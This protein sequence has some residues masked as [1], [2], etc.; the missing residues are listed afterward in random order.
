[1]YGPREPSRLNS[2]IDRG[3]RNAL[4]DGATWGR[5]GCVGHVAGE[6]R[7]PIWESWHEHPRRAIVLTRVPFDADDRNFPTRVH[8]ARTG[9]ISNHLR[10]ILAG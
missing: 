6:A 10:K 5:Y 2:Q 9:Y 7:Q 8:R 4:S 3:V 1:V